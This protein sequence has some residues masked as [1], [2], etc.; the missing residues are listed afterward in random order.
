MKEQL[1]N[2]TGLQHFYDR[3]RTVFALKG[4][5]DANVIEAVKR[6]GTALAVM[7]KA[8]DISVPTKVSEL[9]NDR[10]YQT[11]DQVR[12]PLYETE[13][14][15]PGAFVSFSADWGGLPL[16]SCRAEIRPVQEGSGDP[17]PENVR[18]ITGRT[19]AD[20]RR[21]D[22]EHLVAVSFHQPGE[23]DPAPDNVRPILPGLR[24]T[25]DDGST[26]EVYGGTLDVTGGVLTMTHRLVEFDGTERW[27]Q[28]YSTGDAPAIYVQQTSLPLPL[29]DSGVFSHL[30]YGR[31]VMGSGNG[32]RI[33]LHINW[34][35]IVR[36]AGLTETADMW[37]ASL[38][39]W[40]AA[41]TPFQVVYPLEEP[42]VYRLTP[43]ETERALQ[44]LGYAVRRYGA[45]WSGQAGIVYGGTLDLTGGTLT[46]T[47][48][49][50]GSYAGESLPGAWISDRDVYAEGTAPTAGAQVVYELASPVTYQLTP[51]RVVSL[52]GRNTVWADCGDVTVEY[53]A[54]LQAI[55]QEIE[56]L[57]D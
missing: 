42:V 25:R 30:P 32:A 13:R 19:G 21:T 46:V 55:Q 29:Q 45:D 12:K 3:I 47:H 7:G 23:G 37:K 10:G 17:S 18:P 9:T 8:V 35:C 44:G 22:A 24:L 20:I 11:A 38:A 41:G 34:R 2:K 27:S 26:L 53:G 50:I 49:E 33:Y 57:A 56:R 1:L 28:A 39:D 51:R 6:N 54:F 15:G 14:Y 36:W 40:A 4:E 16:R 43:E 52:P 48:G 31:V 5:A